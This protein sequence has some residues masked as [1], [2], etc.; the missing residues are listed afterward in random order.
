MREVLPFFSKVFSFNQFNISDEQVKFVIS[1]IDKI[2]FQ[3]WDREEPSST[4]L[5][6][7]NKYFLDQ[8]QLNFLKQLIVQDFN[9]YTKEVFKW[10]NHFK[11]TTSWIAK[12]E[13]GKNSHWHNHNNCMYSGILY[14]QTDEKTGRIIFNQ[15]DL[16]R[17]QLEPTEWNDYNSDELY[18]QPKNK[19]IIYFPAEIFHKIEENKSNLTRYSLAFNFV[20]TGV[21]GQ[22][23]SQVII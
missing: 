1:E 6:S 15:F 16:K 12:V 2:S 7:N 17:F 14:L 3:K 21:I 9:N 18:V 4:S 19:T 13:P 23:D 5:A 8:K 10:D 11:M 20:P 22:G